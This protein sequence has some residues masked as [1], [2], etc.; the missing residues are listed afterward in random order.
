MKFA[1]S[2]LNSQGLGVYVLFRHV[3]F[4]LTLTFKQLLLF[5]EQLTL[6]FCYL[7]LVVFQVGLQLSNSVISF[8]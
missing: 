7:L 6:E 8:L 1:L 5:L 3:L 4:P 2:H